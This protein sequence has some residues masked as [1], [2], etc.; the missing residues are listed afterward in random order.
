MSRMK[1]RREEASQRSK[2]SRHR[3]SI[4]SEDASDDEVL[5]T[6]V[7]VA[8]G[9]SDDEE[10]EEDI[11]EEEDAL[12]DFTQTDYAAQMSQA[13]PLAGDDE[14]E[15]GGK[16]NKEPT[17]PKALHKLSD[18]ALDELTAKLVR[19]MLYKGGLKLPIKFADI[20][21]EVFS[22]YKSVSRY[23]FYHAKQKIENV[24]GY[25]VVQV[26]DS[27]SK[28]LYL[29]LNNA[30]SQ[31][32]L[33]LMNKTG[34]AASRGFLMM[35]LGLLWC[36][37]ARRLSEDDLWKQLIRLD[38]T[39]KLKVNH[40]QLGDIPLRFKTF[41]SQLYLDSTSE[42]DVDLKKIKFYQYGPRT[43]LEVSKVQILNFVCKVGTKRKRSDEPQWTRAFPH[44]DGNWPSH[45]RIDIPVTQE[46]RELARYAIKRAQGI[47]GDAVT[48]VPFEELGLGEASSTGAN[49]GL[50]LSLSRP[51]VLTYAQINGLV[52]SLR[53]ALK[54]QQ[55]FNVT[56]RRALLLVNDDKT[57]SF[58]ALRVAEGEQQ[59]TQVLRCVD[60]C[61][62]RFELPTYYKVRL[63]FSSVA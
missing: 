48:L 16:R 18:K 13:E 25:R 29:V 21:K 34:K 55:R 5:P 22:Q 1:R 44:V 11:D 63:L 43:F 41:E 58:L 9:P 15:E 56:L 38:P 47:V 37:P 42:L 10:K 32:H 6:Y 60:Q 35:V 27:T 50:H 7:V 46:L 53:A 12:L 39:V 19:Y 30:S 61:L 40:P 33:L 28:E 14:E 31:E 57:R 54:W 45:V 20:S 2:R 4:G 3:D 62:S 49:N 36:A 17:M 51:F 8:D 26:E 24:F 52:E 59:F 23:F